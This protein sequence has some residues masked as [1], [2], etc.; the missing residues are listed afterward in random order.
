MFNLLGLCFDSIGP[1]TL[2]VAWTL[3]GDLLSFR[4]FARGALATSCKEKAPF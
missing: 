1:S 2:S 4:L 3:M